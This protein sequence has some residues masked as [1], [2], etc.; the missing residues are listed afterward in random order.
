MIQ[1]RKPVPFVKD[2]YRPGF[3]ALLQINKKPEKK[4]GK[5]FPGAFAAAVGGGRENK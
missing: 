2:C 4:S 5:A 1:V 3:L